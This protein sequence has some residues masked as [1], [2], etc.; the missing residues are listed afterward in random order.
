MNL[1]STQFRVA[2]P[3]LIAGFSV[4]A[5]ANDVEVSGSIGMGFMTKGS[6]TYKGKFPTSPYTTVDN[7]LNGTW[8][9]GSLNLGY[10]ALRRGK[11]SIW[12]HGQYSRSLAQPTL[13]HDGENVASPSVVK[14]TFDGPATYDA[15]FFGLGVSYRVPIGEVGLIA[16]P[17]AQ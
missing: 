14:E 2:L 4:M 12:V 13:H 15:T 3:L 16:G 5:Q 11:W 17:R 6:L 7:N 1:F 8:R 9:I 10:E